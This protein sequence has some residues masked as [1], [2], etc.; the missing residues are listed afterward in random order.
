MNLISE[1]VR[2]MVDK[3]IDITLK[4]DPIK[5]KGEEKSPLSV[6]QQPAVLANFLKFAGLAVIFNIS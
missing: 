3:E 2:K 6:L 1:G 4:S 5:Y